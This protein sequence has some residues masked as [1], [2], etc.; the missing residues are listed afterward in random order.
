[1]ESLGLSIYAFLVLLIHISKWSLGRL[2]SLSLKSISP[3]SHHF[4]MPFSL[5]LGFKGGCSKVQG[6]PS[7]SFLGGI[8]GKPSKH[9]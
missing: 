1:M 7:L 8:K 9:T 2:Y 4:P 3:P 5:G 6:T